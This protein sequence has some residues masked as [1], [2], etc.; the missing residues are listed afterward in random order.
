M[1]PD[2]PSILAVSPPPCKI[3]ARDGFHYLGQSVRW[4][5]GGPNVFMLKPRISFQARHSVHIVNGLRR[6]PNSC[7]ALPASS[8]IRDRIPNETP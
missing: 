4:L 8:G 6:L 1:A 7:L 5:R 3:E 2:E